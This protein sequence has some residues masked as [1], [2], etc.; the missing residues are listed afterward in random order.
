MNKLI[1]RISLPVILLLMVNVTYGQRSVIDKYL[2]HKVVIN[3]LSHDVIAYVKPVDGI[4]PQSDRTYYWFSANK[5]NS[6]QGGYSGR[7]L[8]GS[9]QDFYSNKSLKESGLFRAGLKSGKWKS[10][11]ESGRLTDEYNWSTG[12][13]NGQY[14]K[15]DSL[16]NVKEKGKYRN[17][18]LNGKQ[19]TFA[20]GQEKVV[21]YKKG[22]ITERKKLKMP[23][24]ISNIFKK[25]P[26]TK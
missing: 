26:K 7:L 2:T 23:A 13:K 9:F 16:G 10:W 25:K 21:L 11:I 12:R 22:K 14:I 18:L 8:N 3:D 15:Y 24:F 19:R 20:A 1:K 5:I 17:D 6:T 4:V